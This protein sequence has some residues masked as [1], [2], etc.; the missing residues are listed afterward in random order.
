M[1]HT[2]KSGQ[3]ACWA[4]EQCPHTIPV[5]LSRI[6]ASP[7]TVFFIAWRRDS[8]DTSVL[9]QRRNGSKTPSSTLTARPLPSLRLVPSLRSWSM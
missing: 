9:I 3:L 6:W 8:T 2:S 1:P 7:A 5:W 4:C